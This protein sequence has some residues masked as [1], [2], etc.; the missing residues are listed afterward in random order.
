M[1]KTIIQTIGPIYGDVENG[2]V[3]GRPNGSIY[4]PSSNTI[5]IDLEEARR[6][7]R[8][9]T[10]AGGNKIQACY[11]DGTTAS[12]PIHIVAESQDTQSY[13]GVS[14]EDGDGVAV[15]TGRN[16]PAGQFNITALYL[17]NVADDVTITDEADYFIVATLYSSSGVAVA[18]YRL[19]V[20]GWSE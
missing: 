4:I 10:P 19:P 14:I 5:I 17:A 18:V 16:Q 8:I 20:V 15:G 1:G 9:T 12:R 2:T 3:F 13:I 11:T 6:Q 7:I